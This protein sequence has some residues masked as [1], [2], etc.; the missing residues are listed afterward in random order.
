MRTSSFERLFF[1]SAVFIVSTDSRVS[2]SLRRICT[3]FLWLL[4]SLEMFLIC[5]LLRWRLPRGFA[6]CLWVMRGL[7]RS[8]CLFDPFNQNLNKSKLSFF[9]SKIKW[10]IYGFQYFLLASMK[11]KEERLWLFLQRE[12]KHLFQSQKQVSGSFQVDG[13]IFACF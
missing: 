8:C 5:C 13:L 6:A 10:S 9:S 12:I 7:S 11:I 1:T 3:Y 2:F 4:S